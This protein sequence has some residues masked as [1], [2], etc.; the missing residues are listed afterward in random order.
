MRKGQ[1]GCGHV[2]K[3]DCTE[4]MQ[5]N[6]EEMDFCRCYLKDFIGEIFNI[7]YIASL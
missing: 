3:Q 1:G 7:L 6:P 5:A 2:V 4:V